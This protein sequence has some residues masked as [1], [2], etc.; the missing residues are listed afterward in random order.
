MKHLILMVVVLMAVISILLFQII[1]IYPLKCMAFSEYNLIRK[2][3]RV[4]F[5]VSQDLRFYNEENGQFNIKGEVEDEK[6]GE[7]SLDR[8]IN[9]VKGKRIDN[10]TVEYKIGAVEKG[11]VDDTSENLYDILISE[12]TSSQDSIQLDLIQLRSNVW[13]IG[14]STSFVMTCYTY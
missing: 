12:F 13:V 8:K 11:E 14:T 10:D 5:N 7:Y 1:S 2:G 6:L 4:I 3:N 9:L